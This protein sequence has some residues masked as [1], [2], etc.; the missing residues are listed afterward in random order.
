M[1]ERIWREREG[2]EDQRLKK[3]REIERGERKRRPLRKKGG[4]RGRVLSKWRGYKFQNLNERLG[5]LGS[6][7]GS[8]KRAAE[9]VR[10]CG[11]DIYLKGGGG[12]GAGSFQIFE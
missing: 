2:D 3:T 9:S 12:F 8:S 6:E 11:K 1:V 5:V 10:T 4:K 7:G